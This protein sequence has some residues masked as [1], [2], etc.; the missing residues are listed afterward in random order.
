[1]RS[2]CC[3]GSGLSSSPGAGA[4]SSRG[5]KPNLRSVTDWWGGG[6]VGK[7]HHFLAS[8]F[9]QKLHA[10]TFVLREGC[11]IIITNEHL[12]RGRKLEYPEQIYACDW[13]GM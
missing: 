3:S 6:V 8:V 1:M 2:P 10:S 12:S 9:L 5:G 7:R 11:L 13:F 4:L